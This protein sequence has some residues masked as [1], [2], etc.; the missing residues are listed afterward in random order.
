MQR[1]LPLVVRAALALGLFAAAEPARAQAPSAPG[2]AADSVRA[3]QIARLRRG[4]WVRVATVNGMERT[5]EVRRTGADSLLLVRVPGARGGT[6][7]LGAADVRALWEAQGRDIGVDVTTG[8]AVGGVMFGGLGLLAGGF[9][10]D[11]CDQRRAA[12]L[13]LGTVGGAA[14]GALV[15]VAVGKLLPRWHRLVP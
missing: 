9:M 15:G 10:C 1:H 14:A 12:G 7:A 2:G 11:G 5:G 3:A 6:L 4:A 13:V 8:A